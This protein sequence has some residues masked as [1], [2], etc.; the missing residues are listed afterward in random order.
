MGAPKKIFTLATYDVPL[1]C[2]CLSCGRRSAL[3]A[4]DLKRL[5]DVTEMTS[6]TLISR[7]LKCSHCGSRSTK[8][9]GSNREDNTL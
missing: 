2:T 7:R 4:I 6:L 1:L 5:R 3:E 8:C 9:S